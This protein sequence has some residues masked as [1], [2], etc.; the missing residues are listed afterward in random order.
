NAEVVEVAFD[1]EGGF[2]DGV[3]EGEGLES[4]EVLPWAAR[5]VVGRCGGAWGEWGS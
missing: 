1:S 5:G 2:V 3:R 4:E